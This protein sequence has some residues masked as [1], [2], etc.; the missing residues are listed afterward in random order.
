MAYS[1]QNPRPQGRGEMNG[2]RPITD[3]Q[4]KNVMLRAERGDIITINQIVNRFRKENPI[5]EAFEVQR[6]VSTYYGTELLIEPHAS[7]SRSKFLLTAPGPDTF[8]YLW[9]AE[10]DSDGFRE[11][12]SV[13]AELKAS[14]SEEMPKYS[15]CQKC[16]DPIK[17]LEH[18]RLAAMDNC[19]AIN[20]GDS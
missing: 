11:R 2:T 7:K 1:E 20:S 6:R 14:F 19:S 13:T 4:S 3:R 5:P 16:G 17:S 10:T 15:I 18:E 9:G 8:L 12:W